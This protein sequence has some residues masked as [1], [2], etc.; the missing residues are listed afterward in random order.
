M[1]TIVRREITESYA[2]GNELHPLLQRIYIARGIT[3]E[4]QLQRSLKHIHNP[5]QLTNIEIAVKRLIAAITQQ[6]NIMIVG[7]FDADGATS[8]A[9]A[10]SALQRF[11]AQHIEF[12]VPNRFEF[13]YGLTP[14]IVAVAQKS[15]PK[16][17]ITVDNGISSH[18]GVAAANDYGIDVIVTDHHL[19]GAQLPDAYAIV[20]PNLTV[21]IFPSKN[22]AGVGVIFYVMMALR[23]ALIEKNWFETQALECPSM[24][25][26]L[27]LVALG[28]VA[29]VVTLDHNNRILV[30]QGLMR[31]RNGQCRPGIKAILEIAKREPARLVAS[32]LGFAVGPRLNAAGRLDDMSIGIQC[33]L[34]KTIEQARIFA[35]QL[36]SLNE[37][38]K[39]IES[40]MQQQALAIIEK[41]SLQQTQQLPVGLC[42]FDPTWHQ[43]VIG[44]LAGRIKERVHRPVIA[45]A[46]TAENELKGSA[47][48]IKD[49][50]IRDILDA[51]ATQNPGL[52]SK[53]GGHAMAAGMSI[54]KNKLCAFNDAFVAEIAKHIDEKTLQNEIVSDGNLQADELTLDMAELLREAGPW[55]QNFTE[56]LFDNEF[57]IVQQRLLGEKHI[58]FLL[59]LPG[60]EKMFD[61]IAFN[62][63]RTQWPQYHCRQIHA[64]Y[65]LDVNDYQGFRSVQLV[66]EYMRA[67]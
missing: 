63:D 12:L 7:D 24:A 3:S 18:E 6:Q 20:N 65:R 28:T 51:V 66:I 1:K 21:D 25:E 52:I 17:L 32:D 33:L 53:F 23:R 45:F 5:H 34:S 37:E 62:I 55:G 41:L 50:H 43:G 13:G 27:D 26:F 38:R 8:T 46:E 2:L 15:A 11:G 64:A 57:I 35:E 56:P 59:K 49:I 19:P 61:A 30:Q 31:I 44:I 47:R 36:N 39:E 10:V 54:Q 16:V 40:G 14:E 67:L 29:D 58:K 60:N 22:L 42:L 9:L 48:S 4:Q